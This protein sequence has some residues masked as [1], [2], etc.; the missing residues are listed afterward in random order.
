[1]ETKKFQFHYLPPPPPDPLPQAKQAK[2]LVARHIEEDL[3]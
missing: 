3:F 2:I 1:M